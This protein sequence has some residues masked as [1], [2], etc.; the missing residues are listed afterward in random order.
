MKR[1]SNDES[2]T[3]MANSGRLTIARM[4]ISFLRSGPGFA[5]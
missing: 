2:E 4:K 1:I 3:R 5:S